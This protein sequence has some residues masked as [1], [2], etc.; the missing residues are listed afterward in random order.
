M[1][2]VERET[3]IAASLAASFPFLEGKVK[4][5]RERRIWAEV[6]L[7]RFREVFDRAAGEM[8]FGSICIITG[9]DEGEDLG[10]LYHLADESGVVLSLL[11]KA[12]KADPRIGTVTDRFPGAH[13]YERELVDLFGA[14]VEGLPPGNRYPLPDDWPAGEYPLRKDW[15]DPNATAGPEEPRP[16]IAGAA[17]V[18]APEAPSAQEAH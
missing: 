17:G 7:G 8:G 11:T 5:Q 1:S 10:F 13:I 14:V 15:R 6:E 2:G 12:P 18:G 4:V 9:L 16:A 3:G